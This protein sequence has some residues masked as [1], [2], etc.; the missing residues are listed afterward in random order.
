MLLKMFALTVILLCPLTI[1]N[2]CSQALLFQGD[3][4]H[5]RFV[6]HVDYAHICLIRMCKSCC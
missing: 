6:L 3:L 5:V 1:G 4:A 2:L